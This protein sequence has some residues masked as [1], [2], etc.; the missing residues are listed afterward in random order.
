MP[1]RSQ[2]G[3]WGVVV[4]APDPRGL[5]EF[6]AALLGWPMGKIEPNWV[7][8]SSPCGPAF[9]G[10]QSSPEYVRPTWPPAQGHQQMMMHLDI[11]VEDLESAAA[12][13]VSLGATVAEHQPQ[14]QV[15]VMLDPVGHP[16]CLYLDT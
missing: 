9:L 14:E 4:D 11:G 2:T 5:A 15:R 8:V 1:T 16:F 12:D 6:Y 13:A 3:W 10:F 7:T